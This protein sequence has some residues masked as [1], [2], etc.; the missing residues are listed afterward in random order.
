VYEPRGVLRVESW[1]FLRRAAK[2]GCDCCRTSHLLEK[3][4]H[5]IGA[6]PP[7]SLSSARG[8]RV[9]QARLCR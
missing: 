1:V 3:A 5:S 6:Q 2:L 9:F 8:T 4:I 7:H